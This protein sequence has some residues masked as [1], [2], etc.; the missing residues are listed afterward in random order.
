MINNSVKKCCVCNNEKI[1]E[2]I[3]IKDN[4]YHLCCI[5]NLQQENEKIKEKIE[6]R[7]DFI[8]EQRKKI[9]DELVDN[10]EDDVVLSGVLNHMDMINITI[11]TQ[12]KTIKL[13]KQENKELH[14][15]I[16]KA[17]KILKEHFVE[18]YIRSCDTSDGVGRCEID[19]EHWTYKAYEILKDGDL[20][21]CE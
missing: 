17:I 14:N 18:E 20:D 10:I 3:T 12:L 4:K 11:D 2:F 21:E 16:D 9:E 5:E 13:L 19:T 7:G 6:N 15:K 1:G 8:V